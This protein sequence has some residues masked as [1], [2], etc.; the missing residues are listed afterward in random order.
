M[1]LKRLTALI[2]AFCMMASLAVYADTTAAATA[3]TVTTQV[4]AFDDYEGYNVGTKMYTCSGTSTYVKQIDGNKLIELFATSSAMAETKIS[5]QNLTT[6][7]SVISGFSI[8]IDE[9]QKDF[10][11]NVRTNGYVVGDALRI[12]ADGSVKLGSTSISEITVQ[13]DTW[14]DVVLECNMKSGKI[15]A[16][17][18]G[19]N[20]DGIYDGQWSASSNNDSRSTFIINKNASS[21]VNSVIYIDNFSVYASDKAFTSLYSGTYYDFEELNNDVKY[22]VSWSISNPAGLEFDIAKS[23]EYGKSLKVNSKGTAYSETRIPVANMSGELVVEFDYKFSQ[24]AKARIGLIGTDANGTYVKDVVYLFGISDNGSFVT[25]G[26]DAVIANSDKLIGTLSYDTWYHI[27]ISLNT[28]DNSFKMTAASSM[29]N[30]S[31]N[32]IIG[33][34]S[35]KTQIHNVNTFTVMYP[36]KS[37]I[38]YIDNVY[39][40]SAD[41]LPAISAISPANAQINQKEN[42]VRVAFN[43]DIASN[44]ADYQFKVNTAEVTPTIFGNT[45]LLTLSNNMNVGDFYFVEASA[46]DSAGNAI[47]GASAL[48]VV[49]EIIVSDFAYDANAESGTV[50]AGA[51][52]V[53][54]SDDYTT[55]TLI[56]AV[57]SGNTLV[58]IDVNPVNLTRG[59]KTALESSVE[60]PAGYENLK[61]VSY[62]WNSATGTIIPF[63]DALPLE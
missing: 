61:T 46:V 36:Q 55:A 2:A 44:I 17:I 19:G 37:G 25:A 4:V 60:L 56:T 23:D 42:K 3:D 22:P 16:Q 58:A 34:R 21:N 31:A 28:N 12:Y 54:N 10:I 35:G 47:Y 43:G 13:E 41:T 59:V 1:K 45:A 49:D 11:Y 48:R 18:K 29:D 27:A 32:D 57:Y 6:T 33:V 26:A 5:L 8:Y 40:K 51:N 63:A 38:D 20:I 15:R 50:G 62:V 53:S 7:E 9:N 30:L 24:G 52:V 14:Y 39:I